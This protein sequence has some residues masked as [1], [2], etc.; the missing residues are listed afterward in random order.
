MSR[1]LLVG[2]TVVVAALGIEQRRSGL[3]YVIDLDGEGNVPA[4]WSGLLLVAAA[5]SA[6]ATARADRRGAR[7]PWWPLALLFS[8]MAGDEVFGLHEW[9]EIQTGVDWETLYLPVM[10]VGAAAGL[11]AVLRLRE[12][13]T[14]AAGFL[15]AGGAWAIAQVLEAVQWDGD[16]PVAAYGELMAAEEILEMAG[17]L[18]FTL[19]LIAAAERLRSRS[20]VPRV[21]L[22][23]AR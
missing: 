9:L 23:R 4:I 3:G 2:T 14:L 20:F 22:A 13:A 8:F 5:G 19:V 11:G 16:R 10:A 7:W 21:Q 15:A 12:C 6:L 1:V 17:S 18:G